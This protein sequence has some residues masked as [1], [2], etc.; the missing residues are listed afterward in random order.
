MGKFLD[1]D[2]ENK[3]KYGCRY[4]GKENFSADKITE[5]ELFELHKWDKSVYNFK[6]LFNGKYVTENGTYSASSETPYEWFIKEWFKP[7]EY[8]EYVYFE[9]WHDDSVYVNEN[10]ELAVKPTCRPSENRLFTI[11]TVSRGTERLH[12]LAH[13]SD[14]VIYCAGNHPMQVASAFTVRS[15][16]SKLEYDKPNPKG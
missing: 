14:I 9:S 4:F 15:E 11:E 10:G 16:Y 3:Y 8:G 12:A 7:H 5:R 13:K 2:I 1:K 6:S